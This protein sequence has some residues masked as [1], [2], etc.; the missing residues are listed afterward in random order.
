MR[1]LVSIRGSR[2]GGVTRPQLTRSCGLTRLTRISRGG[3]TAD[4]T[5]EH[6]R[7]LMSDRWV[8]WRA[9]VDRTFT[10]PGGR[11]WCESIVKVLGAPWEVKEAE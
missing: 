6:G 1:S 5:P 11:D 9:D 4:V 2:V 10:V 3:V 8:V 7:P